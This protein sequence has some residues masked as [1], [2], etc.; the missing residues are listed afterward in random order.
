[1]PRV[2]YGQVH[3]YN[4]YYEGTKNNPSYPYLYSLGI[5]YKSQIYAQNNYFAMDQGLIASDLIQVLGGTQFTDQGTVLNGSIVNL[6][7]RQ[8]LSPVELDLQ[9]ILGQWVALYKAHGSEG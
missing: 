1:V 7:A 5:G 9:R 8:N 2:R 3:V 4:N 6:A